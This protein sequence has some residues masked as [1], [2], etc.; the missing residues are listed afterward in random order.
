MST[1]IAWDMI[2]NVACLYDSVSGVAFG[3]VFD[4]DEAYEDAERFRK[5]LEPTDARKL[6]PQELSQA[7]ARYF[8][9]VA[10]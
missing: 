1:R 6:T 4:S 7:R 3:E 8:A 2:D 5:W 9:G 10:A